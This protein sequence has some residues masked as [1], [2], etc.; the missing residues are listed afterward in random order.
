M[1]LSFGDLLVPALLAGALGWWGY[2][3]WTAH[4]ESERAEQARQA[5]SAEYLHAVEAMA[6]RHG[7]T[8]VL[9]DKLG[10]IDPLYT[11]NVQNALLSGTGR[12]VVLRGTVVDLEKR[13][14]AYL[15]YLDDAGTT[16]PAIRY[17]LGCDAATAQQVVSRRA[18]TPAVTVA[19]TIASVE[20]GEIPAGSSAATSAVRFVAKGRCLEITFR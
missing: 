9:T 15:V 6:G 13:D 17:V 11:Y 20:K 12:A 5:A 19:A 1:K 10:Q 8:P 7:A 18:A 16:T 14:D 3:R 2:N 4:A